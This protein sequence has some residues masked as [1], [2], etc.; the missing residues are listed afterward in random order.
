MDR[1]WR[2][3]R[4]QTKPTIRSL[5]IYEEGT[6]TITREW[7]FD[8]DVMMHRII[9][10]IDSELQFFV[11]TELEFDVILPTGIIKSFVMTSSF[12]GSFPK[13]SP[14]SQPWVFVRWRALL[15]TQ[16]VKYLPNG[17]VCLESTLLAQITFA[18]SLSIRAC[19]FE[20]SA[21][22]Q[23]WTSMLCW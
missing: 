13:S 18:S 3:H 4:C 8:D 15:D 23:Q 1:L 6:S 11:W 7:L 5:D 2:L 22:S 9:W 20:E 21:A 14:K 16:V 12:V 19:V 17:V 10:R